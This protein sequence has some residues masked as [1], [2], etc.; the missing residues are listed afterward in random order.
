MSFTRLTIRAR[1]LLAFVAIAAFVLAVSALSLHQL[2]RSN[3]RFADYVRG[4]GARQDLATSV[5]NAAM[6]RAVAARNLVLVTTPQDRELEKAAVTQ[7]DED[8]QKAVA[9]LHAAVEADPDVTAD[10]RALE[11]AIEAVET[12]Y[13]P[14]A[15]EIVGKALADDR[16]T[17]ID[18]MNTR[19]RPL[20][21]KLQ[22]ATSAFVRQEREV[23]RARGEDAAREEAV[24]RWILV[25][26]CVLAVGAALSLGVLLSAAVTR[27]LQRAVAFA[28]RV[29]AG[30]LGHRIDSR[31]SDETGQLLSALGRMNEGLV[32]MV[33]EVRQ[34]ADGIA[35]ASSEIASGNADLSSRTEQQAS[36]LQQ[37]AAT[38]EQM[39]TT[40]KHSSEV[41]RAASQLSRESSDVAGRGGE[42][43]RRVVQTMD[44]INASSRR[45]S[46]IIGVI[47]GIAFQT[48]ILA[49]NAAV[50]AARAGEQGRGFAV[51]AG[52]V[53]SLAQRSAEAARE[54]KSLIGESVDRVEAGT[55]LVADAGRTID[56]VVAQVGRMTALMGELSSANGEQESGIGQ[57]NQAIASIDQGTQQNAALVEES[58]GAAESLSGQAGA[59]QRLVARFQLADA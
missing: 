51:V 36:A 14:V 16:D 10:E 40:A 52:E 48:N 39:N 41:A 19:C 25:A 23:A 32:R 37:T 27:P 9:A 17:A 58:A 44:E 35:M 1:L 38:M 28:E 11:A 21:A 33:T 55:S 53:R 46:D 3:G 20:L 57:V 13:R 24:D 8:T 59:L 4:V 47:D 15:L 43:V 26:A 22:E 56:E 50:E 6:R 49:L 45:I 29:A 31:R 5:R 34:A 54:I 7:S 18:H 12:Q 42:A 30:D 2:A